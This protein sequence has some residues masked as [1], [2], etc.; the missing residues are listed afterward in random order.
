MARD[1][2]F[3][4]LDWT[5]ASRKE[6]CPTVILNGGRIEGS[7]LK[8]SIKAAINAIS[9]GGQKYQTDYIEELYTIKGADRL[10][11]RLPFFNTTYNSFTNQFADTF[12]QISQRG[13]PMLG[14]DVAESL[15]NIATSVRVGWEQGKELLSTGLYF[16]PNTGPPGTYIQ[17]PMFWQA[18]N[19]AAPLMVSFVLSNTVHAEAAAANLA[20]INAFA[21]ANKAKRVGIKIDYPMV[22]QLEVPGHRYMRWAY[23]SSF[24][25]GMLGLRKQK[26]GGQS[27]TS[28][29]IIP[30]AYS[31]E[32]G[33]TSLTLEDADMLT[34]SIS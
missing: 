10:N 9:A 25:V 24:N 34:K 11:V 15:L 22:Y 26:G 7:Q 18:A 29:S 13:N 27:Q 4:Q 14:A 31:C 28:G 19:T 30:E 20:A 32:F 5:S 23:C 8:R 6:D 17:T 33:F 3:T 16:G 21:K 1:I 2:D 12:S